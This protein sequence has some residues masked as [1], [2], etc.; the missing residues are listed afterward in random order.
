MR[1]ARE[2]ELARGL[3]HI[4]KIVL[5][6]EPMQFVGISIGS[7]SRIKRDL[8][9][10][11]GLLRSFDGPVRLPRRDH[12]T[13]HDEGALSLLSEDIVEVRVHLEI[14]VRHGRGEQLF[15]FRRK[16]SRH[17]AVLMDGAEHVEQ[18]RERVEDAAWIKVAEAE[19]APVSAA[20][21][22]RKDGLE[23]RMPLRG[24]APLL[25]GVAGDPDHADVTVTPRLTADPLD[26][27]IVV[28]IFT[29]VMALGFGR[30]A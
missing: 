5:R 26:H 6:S 28:G 8:D 30:A 7:R 3:L 18:I 29:A 16:L 21:V 4:L 17:I 27:I 2:K 12:G 1:R 24:G 25:A 20:G 22:V 14:R 13:V 19:H 9:L 11:E 15:L 23:S 10:L